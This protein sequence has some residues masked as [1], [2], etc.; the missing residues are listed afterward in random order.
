MTKPVRTLCLALAVVLGT[1]SAPVF[2]DR[3][4]HRGYYDGPRHEYRGHRD[5]YRRDYRDEHRRHNRWVGP[6]AI[7]AIA[8]LAAGAAAWAAPPAPRVYVAPPAPVYRAPEQAYWSYCGSAGLYYPDVSYCP[9]GWQ[10][11]YR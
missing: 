11:V 9:E 4:G 10:R 7:L 8:G 3:D 2:A 1:A 6:A 5:D